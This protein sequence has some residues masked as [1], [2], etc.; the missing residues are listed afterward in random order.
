MRVR[1]VLTAGCVAAGLLAAGLPAGA[2][3]AAPTAAT[4]TK[5]EAQKL[6]R[7]GVL[8]RSD[9]PKFDVTRDIRGAEDDE[10][11]ARFYRCLGVKMPKYLVR[12]PGRSFDLGSLSIESS[13]DVLATVRQARADIKAVGSK[14]GAT[15]FQQLLL[16]AYA[17]QGTEVQSLSIKKIPVTVA[18]ADQAFAFRLQATFSFEGDPVLVDGLLLGARVGQTE[19]SLAP[20]RFGGGTPSLKQARALVNKLAKRVAAI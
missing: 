12:D 9:L 13:A 8:T 16:E 2:A 17:E 18:N 11:D 6:A 7:A 10:F 14:K 3:S 1:A 5:T 4:I 19:I 15:C 20:G